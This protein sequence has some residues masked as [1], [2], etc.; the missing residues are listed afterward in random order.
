VISS[1]V[2][3]RTTIS[4]RYRPVET[5]PGLLE[6]RRPPDQLDHLW[7][8]RRGTNRYAVAVIGTPGHRPIL[9]VMKRGAHPL[10]R[11]RRYLACAGE[12]A[13]PP[14]HLLV[15]DNLDE[16]VLAATC[17]IRFIEGLPRPEVRTVNHSLDAFTGLGLLS[18]KL[19]TARLQL[20]TL[21]PPPP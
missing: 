7:D 1:G 21:R 2:E 10:I 11:E 20:P 18:P 17:F 9:R 6:V 8:H 15:D 19:A 3:R 14:P 13:D 5:S 16:F 4:N 12:P